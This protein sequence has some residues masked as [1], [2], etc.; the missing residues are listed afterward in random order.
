MAQRTGLKYGTS[1][2][3]YSFCYTTSIYFDAN[4][5]TSHICVDGDEV[6]QDW[7]SAE[8]VYIYCGCVTLDDT[9][10]TVRQETF[11]YH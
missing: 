5:C 11:I 8:H 3:I 7:D 2:N 10:I 9:V 4:G 1:V 6:S